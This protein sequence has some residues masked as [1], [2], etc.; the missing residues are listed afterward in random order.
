MTTRN[1]TDGA[2]EGGQRKDAALLL[3]EVTRGAYI[4]KARRALLEVLLRQGKAT[5]DDV[6]RIVELPGTIN[7]KLFG[8]VV[9]GLARAGII[10]GEGYQHTGRPIA[11]ARPVTIWRL[12]DA[13]KAR[14]WLKAYPP[15]PDLKTGG[16][17]LI[18]FDAK[19]E[20]PAATFGEANTAGAQSLSTPSN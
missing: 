14:H 20:T 10:R 1:R 17:L 13:A 7:P 8:P 9:L 12:V 19:S 11:H 4:R 3:L 2:R 18:D 15:L 5:I 6:R 16:Q